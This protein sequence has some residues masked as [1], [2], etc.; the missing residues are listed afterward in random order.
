M[1]SLAMGVYVF[2]IEQP[3]S[4]SNNYFVLKTEEDENRQ[5]GISV[6][7]TASKGHKERKPV[8][9]DSSKR[10]RADERTISIEKVLKGLRNIS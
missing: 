2:H 6:R 1:V 8:D 5:K 3:L 9:V 4:P 7:E 10:I